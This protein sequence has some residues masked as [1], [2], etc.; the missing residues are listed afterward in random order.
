MAGPTNPPRTPTTTDTSHP[1]SNDHSDPSSTADASTTRAHATTTL[2]H[3]QPLSASATTPPR[4]RTAG[5][6]SSGLRPFPEYTDV[7]TPEHDRRY[8]RER[9][10]YNYQ[11]RFNNPRSTIPHQDSRSAFPVDHGA[12]QSASGSGSRAGTATSDE[13]NRGAKSRRP[14][15]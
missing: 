12:Q 10:Q 6:S 11:I 7:A 13:G 9:S 14:R 3:P 15:V 4:V 5:S 8:Y 1:S 2:P